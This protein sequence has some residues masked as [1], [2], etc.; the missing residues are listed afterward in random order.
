MLMPA[1]RFF[2]MMSTTD[3]SA[4]KPVL[5][6]FGAQPIK[7]LIAAPRVGAKSAKKT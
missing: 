1:S 6:K 4:I 7:T 3:L 5:T 2:R